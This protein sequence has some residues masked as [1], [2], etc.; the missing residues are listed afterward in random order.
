MIISPKHILATAIISLLS[1]SSPANGKSIILSYLTST[2][3]KIPALADRGLF[4]TIHSWVHMYEFINKQT[5]VFSST[6]FIAAQ[7]D[8][9]PGSIPTDIEGIRL[10]NGIH[11]NHMGRVEILY[12]GTW[13]T[14]C[15][16]SWS[17]RDTR[18]ACRSA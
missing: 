16:D 14:I 4:Q 9:G 6:S 12:N 2:N 17:I 13:G 15:D 7:N 3:L 1:I 18:V 5:T 8:D 11:G 10:V